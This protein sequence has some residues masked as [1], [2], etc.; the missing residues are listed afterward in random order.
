M[1]SMLIW[2]LAVGILG[3]ICI[4]LYKS[5]DSG[6]AEMA[7]SFASLGMF[8]EAFGMDVLSIA[9]L[10]GFFATEVGTVH[11]LGSS[12]FAASIA[13]VILSKEE[14]GHTAEFTFT[15]PISRKKV[16]L[17]KYLAVFIHILVFALIC[18]LCY[19]V[20]FILLKENDMGSDFYLYMGFQFLMNLEVAAICF[21]I[22]AYSKKN[23]LGLGISLAMLL[24][25]FDLMARVLPDLKKLKFLTPFA[26][27]NA[28]DI[29]SGAAID[30]RGLLVGGILFAGSLILS[31][32]VYNKRD[33]AS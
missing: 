20:G 11:A 28:A 8:S 7:D 31:E 1:K 27:A 18:T 12:M 17:M 25:A 32:Y 15:L 23:K 22:S 3:L 14:D 26:Y 29:L 9:T 33:L 21:V 5:M 13:T 6:M 10:K 24:Y 2:S 30:R 19:Q 16:I 4:L